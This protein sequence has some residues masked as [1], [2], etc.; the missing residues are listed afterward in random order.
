MMMMKQEIKTAIIF[1]C[2]IVVG[3]GIA[4]VLFSSL[5]SAQTQSVPEITDD[6]QELLNVDKSGFKQAP[7]I[8]GIAHHLNTTPEELEERIADSVVMYDIWTYSCINCLRTLPY[9]TAWDE[10]YADQGLLIIGVHSPEFEFEKDAENV[11]RAV[12]KHGIKYPVVMDNDRETW[13]AFENRYWPR[14]FVAD[15]EGFIRYDR[16]GEGGYQETERVIQRLLAERA[17][18]FGVQTAAAAAASAMPLVELEEFEHT[19]FRTPELY[20]GYYFAQNRNHLGSDEGFRP[21][22]TVTYERP[23][24]ISQDK[25]YMEGTW[26]NGRDG[27]QLVG[28]EG[29]VL[30]KYSAKE[31]NIVTSGVGTIQVLVDGE[32]ISPDIAGADVDAATGTIATDEPR[33]YNVVSAESSSTHEMELFIANGGDFEIFTFTFG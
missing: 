17:A 15:H 31:V 9:I 10:K 22:Q 5:D 12:T 25:F 11:Q 14:K 18:A 3:I 26:E 20:F 7:D 24:S 33:L 16:I 13:D 6:L 21:G 29:S 1:A 28:E 23:A 27:M 19:A 4:G 32:P 2:V 8:V 30:L